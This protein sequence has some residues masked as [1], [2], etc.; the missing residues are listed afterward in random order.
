[1]RKRLSVF[2]SLFLLGIIFCAQLN[3]M[4]KKK[5]DKGT[6]LWK[7]EIECEG[8]GVQGT[9]LLKVWT[10]SNKPDNAIE[11]AK[12]N[13]V[14]GVIFK[15]FGS[16]DRK[17]PTQKPLARNPNLEN[18]KKEFFKDFFSD[19]GKYQKFVTL[20]ADGAIGPGDIQKIDKKK[21]KVGVVVSVSKDLLRKDL[22]EAGVIKKL[23]FLF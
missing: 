17:C 5:E 4:G 22:E 10:Y 3:A 2:I 19:G 11:Q 15:G 23:D 8:V 13:A 14:H 6:F 18:E 1:M 16:G 9:Y 12:K 21:Y 7:Y 20:T